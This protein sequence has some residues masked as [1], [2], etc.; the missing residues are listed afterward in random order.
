MA[1]VVTH[2]VA[3]AESAAA[4]PSVE[5]VVTDAPTT[6]LSLKGR[7]KPIVVRV[8]GG[9]KKRKYSRSLKG[10]QKSMRNSTKGGNRMAKAITAGLKLYTKRADKSSKKRR[11][12]MIRDL[13]KNTASGFGKTLRKSSR[14]PSIFA[15]S[16]SGK[17]V[18]RRMRSMK[19]VMGFFR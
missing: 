5:A 16:V 13:L 3:P 11:D 1:N 10:L 12:G 14:V 15:K 2:K 8:K 18:R 4:A 17:M 9:R 19:N 6:G 7:R